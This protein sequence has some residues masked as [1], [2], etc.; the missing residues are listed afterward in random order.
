MLTQQLI[1]DA[2]LNIRKR[3][4]DEPNSTTVAGKQT[5]SDQVFLQTD[6]GNYRG[7]LIM[8][9]PSTIYYISLVSLT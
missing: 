2:Y 8:S 9:I 3:F 4:Y 1:T 6:D 7:Y 5:G